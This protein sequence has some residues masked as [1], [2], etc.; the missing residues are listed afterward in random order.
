MHS[1]DSPRVSALAGGIDLPVEVLLELQ[2]GGRC[3]PLER[4]R[5]RQTDRWAHYPVKLWLQHG[6]GQEAVT[7]FPVFPPQASWLVVSLAFSDPSVTSVLYLV[8][9]FEKDSRVL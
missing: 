6:A 3:V 4:E 1:P 2:A 8:S 5:H 9:S 7:Y